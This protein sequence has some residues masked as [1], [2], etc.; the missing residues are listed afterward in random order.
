MAARSA[1][2][3][4]DIRSSHGYAWYPNIDHH[5]ILLESGDVKARAKLRDMEICQSLNYIRQML[6][7]YETNAS[8]G[9]ELFASKSAPDSF[10][11]SL[12]E[13]WRG[14]ICHCAITNAYGSIKNYKVKDASMHNWMALAL[15]VRNNDISDFPVCNKSFNLSYCG[16]DL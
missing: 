5:P 15:A 12:T 13:G 10:V 6:A 2:I 11:I 7:R 4:R 8:Q 14:E 9:T 16:N 3:N 1:G